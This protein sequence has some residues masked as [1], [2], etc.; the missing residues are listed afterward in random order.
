MTPPTVAFLGEPHKQRAKQ[1][2]VLIA[3]GFRSGEIRAGHMG[4]ATPPLDML[5]ACVR[6]LIWIPGHIVGL[7]GKR[8][9]LRHSRA[10]LFHG[11]AIWD[12]DAAEAEVT[13]GLQGTA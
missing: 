11:A 2:G 4:P 6:D 3:E 7:L 1:I 12:P 8:A 13:I 10:T 5:A 9:A